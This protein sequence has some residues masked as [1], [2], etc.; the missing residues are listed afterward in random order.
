MKNV[1]KNLLLLAYVLLIGYKRF[2]LYAIA[3]FW[4]IFPIICLQSF[5]STGFEYFVHKYAELFIV[6]GLAWFPLVIHFGLKFERFVHKT[7]I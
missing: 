1:I 2:S 3:L 6:A 5:P 4:F 7:L